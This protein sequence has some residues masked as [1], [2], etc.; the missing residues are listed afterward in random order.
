[1]PQCSSPTKIHYTYQI[2]TPHI[3]KSHLTSPLI[4]K[5]QGSSPLPPGHIL[6]QNRAVQGGIL[7]KEAGPT[8]TNPTVEPAKN[9]GEKEGATRET[10]PTNRIPQQEL[11]TRIRDLYPEHQAAHSN[12]FHAAR[13]IL[14]NVQSYGPKTISVHRRLGK[15]VHSSSDL[16]PGEPKQLPQVSPDS[17]RVAGCYDKLHHNGDQ[18]AGGEDQTHPWYRS[19]LLV[20]S[21]CCGNSVG[22]GVVSLVASSSPVFLAGSTVGFALV[23]PASLKR[24]P[25]LGWVDRS[26]LPEDVAWLRH[27]S[28]SLWP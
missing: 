16:S 20:L 9:T 19:R 18:N 5:S 25:P 7:F 14:C 23:R 11:R 15:E 17:H 13:L 3:Q 27:F 2:P 22:I 12:V 24:I 4:P 6:G 10:T 28:P 21:S 8:R 1:M 26:V